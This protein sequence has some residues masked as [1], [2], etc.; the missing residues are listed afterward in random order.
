[1]RLGE[2]NRELQDLLQRKETLEEAW[3]AAA[4]D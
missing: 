2:L 4:E 3:M 1:V